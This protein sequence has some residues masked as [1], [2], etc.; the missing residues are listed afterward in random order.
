MLWARRERSPHREPHPFNGS[1]ASNGSAATSASK[2]SITSR[3]RTWELAQRTTPGPSGQ[4]T[5]PCASR[6]PQPGRPPPRLDRQSLIG[7]VAC[8][9]PNP[10]PLG[11][12]AGATTGSRPRSAV[13]CASGPRSPTGTSRP[14]SR[15][16][17]GAA[18]AT[19]S[20]RPSRGSAVP[21][22]PDCGACTGPTGIRAST[23]TTGSSRPGR[24]RASSTSSTPARTRSSGAD[25]APPHPAPARSQRPVRARRVSVRA[26]AARKPA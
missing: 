22:P 23:S 15:G 6:T 20:P 11:S 21:G 7:R 13:G 24:C 10:M 19:R 12:S 25:P 1:I 17:P 5:T 18:R 3:S 2:S 9:R 26:R 4:H 14:A 8:H 16:R